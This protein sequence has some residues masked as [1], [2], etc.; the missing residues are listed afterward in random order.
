MMEKTKE[1]ERDVMWGKCVCVD[2]CGRY[3]GSD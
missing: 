1:E 3:C 2:V